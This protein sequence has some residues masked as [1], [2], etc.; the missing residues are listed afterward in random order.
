MADDTQG[1][2]RTSPLISPYEQETGA[3]ARTIPLRTALEIARER[4]RSRSS[5]RKIYRE[6]PERYLGI[7]QLMRESGEIEGRAGATGRHMPKR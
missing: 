2:C 6:E 3:Q 5:R 1:R 4:Q 7:V